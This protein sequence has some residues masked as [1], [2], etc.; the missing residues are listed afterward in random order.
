[1]PNFSS[2]FNSAGSI[3]GNVNNAVSNVSNTSTT[4]TNYP[5]SQIIDQAVDE[6]WGGVTP[7]RGSNAYYDYYFSGQDIRVFIDG[8]EHQA[9]FD[10]FPICELKFRIEQNKKVIYGFWSYVYDAV[11]RGTRV[12]SG[13]FSITTLYPNYM[14]QV[15]ALAAAARAA[16]NG[17]LNYNYYRTLTE[18]DKNIALYWGNNMDP[19][20]Q[21]GQDTNLF[22]THPPFSMVIVYGI[23][24]VSLTDNVA[25]SMPSEENYHNTF[26]T[27]SALT[28]D[29]NDRLIDTNNN[30][31]NESMRIVLD[32]CEIISMS[33]GYDA[34]GNA[35]VETYEFFAR[36]LIV[37][38]T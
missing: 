15:V 12:V 25:P 20:L 4:K 10:D 29:T 23:Q 14:K 26:G 6:T 9:G 13:S 36:D 33:T 2:V 21:G 24:N 30:N 3:R 22:S 38:T 32:D 27:D 19:S 37:P 17:S 7:G 34:S 8:T 28:L 1:M 31:G 11:M 5:A 35:L 18:D 16:N